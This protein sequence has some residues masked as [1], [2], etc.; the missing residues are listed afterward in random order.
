[1]W[2]SRIIGAIQ[3]ELEFAGD[4]EAKPA[5][6]RVDFPLPT[7]P[8]TGI[9]RELS[10]DPATNAG[11]PQPLRT[12]TTTKHGPSKDGEAVYDSQLRITG[13]HNM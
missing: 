4:V 11:A 9:S 8:L 7:E 5:S 1:M 6:D 13:G 2:C 3:S 12:T 10:G